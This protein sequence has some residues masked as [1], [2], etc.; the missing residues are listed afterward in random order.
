[1]D[2]MLQYWCLLSP[3]S[4]DQDVR[5]EEEYQISHI[6]GAVRAGPETSDFRPIYESL[7]GN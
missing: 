6:T 2:S 4:S 1:M 7:K 3:S 5:E